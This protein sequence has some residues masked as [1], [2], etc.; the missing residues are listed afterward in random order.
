MAYNGYLLKIGDYKVPMKFMKPSTYKTYDNMQD[1]SPWTDG[2]GYLHRDAVELK[3]LKVEFETVDMLTNT[4]FEEL[5][6]NLRANFIKPA[7]RGCNIT[8]YIP[9]YND[10]LTQYGYM[11][12]CT[13]SIYGTYGNEIH[14]NSVRLA[15]IGG[16]AK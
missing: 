6:S 15:F 3:A 14:Y 2:Y 7:E 16:V 12:D 4:Q 1:L 8:A 11:A 5:M 9:I 10:Y 13:P